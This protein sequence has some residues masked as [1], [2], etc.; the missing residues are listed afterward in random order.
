M[1]NLIGRLL[2]GGHRHQN[3][4]CLDKRNCNLERVPE[5]IIRHKHTLEELHLDE[6]HIQQLPAM[7][8]EFANLRILG[9]SQNQIQN[10]PPGIQNLQKL[11]EINVSTNNITDIPDDIKNLETLQVVDFSSNPIE[12]LPDGVFHLYNLTVLKL[13]HMLLE[14]LSS[15]FGNLQ[16]LKCLELRSNLIQYLPLSFSNL[17]QLE[18]L[19]LGDNQ[20]EE[21]PRQ[22]CGL[23][24]ID[25]LWLDKNKIEILPN[26][27]GNLINLTFLNI[28]ENFLN[29][30]PD[31]IQG[32]SKVTHL[33]LS[34]NLISYLPDGIGGLLNIIILNLDN[35]KLLK[36]NDNIG[37]C[38]NLEE[39]VL[40]ENALSKL[41]P[42]I[43][44]LSNLKYLSIDGNRLK[45]LP[46]EIGKLTKLGILSL[47]ENELT[48]LPCEISSCIELGVLDVS[49]N[50]LQHLPISFT[51]FTNLKGLWLAENQAKPIPNFQTDYAIDTGDPVLTCFLLPQNKFQTFYVS[52]QRNAEC[53]KSHFSEDKYKPGTFGEIDDVVDVSNII[54]C[55][56]FQSVEGFD[57]NGIE[58]ETTLVRQKTPHPKDLKA[59][60]Q[61]L[62]G[63]KENNKSQQIKDS[64]G[65]LEHA[66]DK[67]KEM[68]YHENQKLV[69]DEQP[70]KSREYDMDHICSQN[71][72]YEDSCKTEESL[73]DDKDICCQD[74][75]NDYRLV[76]ELRNEQQV[77]RQTN[78]KQTSIIGKI[79]AMEKEV[80]EEEH[81]QCNASNET[82][83]HFICDKGDI[84]VASC[85]PHY[86]NTLKKNETNSRTKVINLD[87]LII[88]KEMVIVMV[89]R[90]DEKLGLSISGGLGSTPYKSDDEGVFV[91]KIA[92]GGVAELSGLFKNDKILEVNG[93]SCLCA[94]HQ[95]IVEHMNAA[96]S[97]INLKILREENINKCDEK[98]MKK[99]IW[100]EKTPNN[101]HSTP[102]GSKRHGVLNYISPV[103]YM[104]NRPAFLRRTGGEYRR[105]RL[106]LDF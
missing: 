72:C 59:K 46:T 81:V 27:I 44:N 33:Y 78:S 65:D 57:S 18:V 61:K 69:L 17:T 60:A 100:S 67:C 28:S 25:E 50:C 62:F 80:D 79:N 37:K 35:N 54:T 31:E 55:V 92:T 77:I 10:I 22:I 101:D 66:T 1:K 45:D 51:E 87:P 12:I 2:K 38:S 39:L 68:V 105:T 6:N 95:E 15:E 99:T 40:K 98:E 86:E 58:R 30:I 76:L 106:S 32:L 103:S 26:E 96:A 8:F 14:D 42:T 16:N 4:E 85:S 83:K 19:D 34:D 11:V 21:F 20:I 48:Y 70:E 13:A 49:G 56:K 91:S 47:R 93:N 36:L 71:M 104:A 63:N 102:N 94:T 82:P 24:H 43:G 90:S 52:N 53:N 64:S 97:F 3:L 29:G 23:L 5:N 73:A 88:S 75:E 84:P 89:R 9:L 41:P 7:L 74:A